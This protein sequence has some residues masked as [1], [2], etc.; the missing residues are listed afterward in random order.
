MRILALF[1]LLGGFTVGCTGPMTLPEFRSWT[2]TSSYMKPKEY[3]VEGLTMVT[4]EQKLKAFAN[5]CMKKQVVSKTGVR[6]AY[7]TS[8]HTSVSTYNPHF[9]KEPNLLSFYIQRE[10]TDSV[11]YPD[12][13]VYEFLAEVRPS[14]KGVRVFSSNFSLR[15]PD[16]ILE[17]VESWLRGDGQFCPF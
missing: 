4:A 13:G 3:T 15:M 7:G 12:G 14:P 5:K 17:D 11:V 10:D 9:L 1:I 6:G 8:Y 2:R 16:R